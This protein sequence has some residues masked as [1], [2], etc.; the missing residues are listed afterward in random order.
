[1]AGVKKLV[2]VTDKDHAL[3]KHFSGL[4]EKLSKEFNVPLEYRWGDY[5]YVTQYGDSDELGLTWLPQLFAELDDGSVVKILTQPN[6]SDS[7]Y[8]DE[9]K[10]Y[11]ISAEVLRKYLS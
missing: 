8:L 10:D 1:M 2:L 4:A 7:G 11:R 6:L 3:H 9:K 5:V